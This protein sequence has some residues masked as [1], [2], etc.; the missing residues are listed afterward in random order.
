MLTKLNRPYGFNPEYEWITKPQNVLWV[1]I[2][3]YTL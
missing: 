1:P 2:G 3:Q